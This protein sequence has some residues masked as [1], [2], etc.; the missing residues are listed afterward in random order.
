VGADK[1]DAYATSAA[2]AG[3][4]LDWASYEAVIAVVGETPY[5]EG[6][7][8]IG[9]A[10]TLGRQNKYP[11]AE[12][13]AVLAAVSGHDVPVITVL[14]SGRPL[15]VNKELNLSTAFVAAW[16]PGTEGAGVADVLLRKADGTVNSDFTGKLSYSW[17]KTDCQTPLNV[18]DA[19]YDPLF[20]YGYGLTYAATPPALGALDETTS[21]LGCGQSNVDTST[22]TVLDSAGMKDPYSL[23][24]GADPSWTQL[25]EAPGTP[26]SGTVGSAGSPDPAMT[27]TG[28]SNLTVDV[29][30]DGR[31]AA[32]AGTA[33]AQIYAQGTEADLS[34]FL[35]NDGALVFRGV[36]NAATTASLT[37]QITCGYPC[38]GT[39]DITGLLGAVGEKTT[40]KVPLR[41]FADAGDGFD[42]TKVNAP[43][44]LQTTGALDLT[45][46]SVRWVQGAANDPDAADCATAGV[47]TAA[48]AGGKALT[49]L[50]EANT[51]LDPFILYLGSGAN[52]AMAV[53]QAGGTMLDGT[54][55]TT[56]GL[57]SLTAGTGVTV[58]A[59]GDGKHATWAGTGTAQIYLQGPDRDAT[60][61]GNQGWNL[62]GYLSS[63]GM[64]AFDA[65]VG[66][67]PA[68]SVKAR[69]DCGYPCI[70]ELD[71][72][73]LFTNATLGNGGAH[74]FKIPLSCF[75]GAGTDFTK[76]NTPFLLA[77]DGA[78]DV[79]F[80]NVRWLPG[81]VAAD[82]A[83]CT[84]T[85]LSA[86]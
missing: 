43:F 78:F 17:P 51:L 84:G 47:A 22:L 52:W 12:I 57:L 81:P 5:A 77:T 8:D 7:G 71:A 21:A 14:L 60:L 32:W 20:A 11:A 72:T 62:T 37:A 67:Q 18:G 86:P 19:S 73:A 75:Q 6:Q 83:T 49:F 40:F 2:L 48:P 34:S 4:T 85:V 79:T 25:V 38:R 28:S 64:L 50:S 65:K 80:A 15:W 44:Q 33:Y 42:L 82:A 58:T 59:A 30:G 63:G 36:L 39:V 69:V 74:T 23:Y 35:A 24:L 41:C 10:M 53:E 29:Q 1:V 61:D 3:A 31:R 76:V 27:V 26:L 46:A 45:F 13:Q 56:D 70:G 68:G 55:A 54:V 9:A 66:V 16:L